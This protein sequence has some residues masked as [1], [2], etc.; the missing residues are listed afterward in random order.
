[1]YLTSTFIQLI[2]FFPKHTDE[3]KDIAIFHI[4]SI[5]IDFIEDQFNNNT[6][7]SDCNIVL[8]VI[9]NNQV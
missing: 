3:L 7:Q 2:F 4:K 1:M 6:R 9:I 8:K 5:V